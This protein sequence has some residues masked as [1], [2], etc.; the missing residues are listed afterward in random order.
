M[1][2]L[3]RGVLNQVSTKLKVAA[4]SDNEKLFLLLLPFFTDLVKHSDKF[5]KK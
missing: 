4:Y 2:S 3:N 1:L 5:A